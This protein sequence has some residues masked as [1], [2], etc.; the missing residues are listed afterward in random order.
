MWKEIH[1]EIPSLL[2]DLLSPLVERG[3]HPVSLRAAE[4]V[5]LDKPG[6][7]SYDTPASYRVIVLLETLVKILE[8]LLA[9]RL[10]MQASEL[11]MLHPNQCGSLPGVCSF[12]ATAAL[13][14]EV[15]TVHKL[16]LKASSLILDIKCGFDNVKPETRTGILREKGVSPY[17]VSW[18]RAFLSERSC[19]LRFQ[20]APNS[21][22]KVAVG[23]LQG[24]PISPLLFVLYVAPLHRGFTTANTI[25]F[26]DDLA[27]TS[28]SSSH[29]RNVQ[30][31]QA[32]FRKLSYKA[33]RLGLSFSVPKTELVHW[34]TPMDRTPALRIPIHLGDGIIY[35]REEVRWLGYWFTP[36][37]T[38]TPYFRR[39]LTLANSAFAIIKRLAPPGAGLTPL[40]AHRLAQSLLL[41]VVSYR[42]DLFT[43]NG[44]MLQ[45]LDVFWHRVQRWVT[46]CF[47]STP[48]N[49]LA[50]EAAL[51]LIGLLLAHRRRLAAVTLACTPSP[52]C[53]A[54]ARLPG[55][56]PSPYSYRARATL[57]PDKWRKPL[58]SP[59]P[60]DAL[61]KTRIRTRLPLGDQAHLT[62]PF[63]PAT[64]TFPLRLPHLVPSE[65]ACLDTPSITWPALRAKAALALRE[66]WAS[67]AR[68]AYYLFERSLTPHPF[69]ALPK[70]LAG[71]IHQMRS[72]K[73][74]LV[75]HRPPWS[76]DH[77]LP[78]CPRCSSEDETLTHAVLGCPHRDWARHHFLRAVPSLEPASPMLTSPPL[79]VA[80]AKFIRA[81]ATGFPDC[82]PPLGTDSPY[83][84]PLGSPEPAAPAPPDPPH[85]IDTLVSAFASAWGATV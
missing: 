3:Y 37:P 63:V 54:A 61:T 74:Y 84:T 58:T 44:A 53:T 6:K 81:T 78:T 73:S 11:G 30:L 59:L 1:R 19:R 56:F 79:V 41:P 62:L 47:S 60:W 7:A 75:A 40:W 39:R 8:R 69:M 43:P 2:P 4:G 14:H 33:S 18:V 34:R 24:F 26:V 65:Y 68:P 12:H 85:H 71:R 23:T 10:S 77:V 31:L 15:A 13:A 42:A 21:F 5:V 52:I 55:G 51:P 76:K 32:R 50:V 22:T 45:K 49:I 35:P 64:G 67:V 9:N 28:V 70:F 17:I 57:R 83:M 82:M 29:R 25:S 16:K 27:L 38:S 66:E 46:N 36:N 48:V 20:G 80:L 72:G